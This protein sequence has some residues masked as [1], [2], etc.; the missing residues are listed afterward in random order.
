MT[1]SSTPR[2]RDMAKRSFVAELATT[3]G[4]HE[5]SASRLVA[6]AERLTGPRHATLDALAAGELALTQVR[7]VLELTH[8]LPVEVADAVEQVALDAASAA[9]ANGVVSTNADVRRRMRRVRERLHPQPLADRR[10]R[11]V[12]DRRVC[13]DPAPDGMAW[14]SLHLE[15]ERAVAIDAR[16]TALAARPTEAGDMRTSLQRAVDVAADLLLGGGLL[17]GGLLGG[18]LLGGGLLDD[19]RTRHDATVIGA[20]VP[21]I[22]V[23]VP[24]LTLLGLDDEPAELEGY[25]PIDP[26]TAR[27]LTV[28]APWIRRILVHPETGAVVS[29]GRERYRVPADLAGLVRFRDGQCRFPG[30]SRPA[31]HADLD[32]TTAFARGGTTS[33]TNLAALCEPHH[34]LKHESRWRVLQEPGGVMRWT[35]PAGHVLRTLPE[36]PFMPVG[37]GEGVDAADAACPASTAIARRIEPPPIPPDPSPTIDEEWQAL[38]EWYEPVPF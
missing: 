4:R 30:C 31:T 37:A 22:N 36:R 26:E 3:L 17:G 21:R 2:E 12:D 32:H 10:A 1:E 29:Y 35:S 24:V 38:L 19:E 7:S 16:L 18:G 8:D 33:A 6:E 27:L 15:A 9:A 13:L 5:A 11:A 34:H 28:H 25:G 20:V 14:L 23:T